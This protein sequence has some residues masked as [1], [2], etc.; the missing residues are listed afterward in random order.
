MKCNVPIYH[1]EISKIVKSLV[2]QF[3]IKSTRLPLNC[4]IYLYT[5]A[6][7]EVPFFKI[8]Y[9]ETSGSFSKTF[10]R[11]LQLLFLTRYLLKGRVR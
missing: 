5:E 10:I 6:R 11:K 9:K 7:N 4:F 8:I 2:I 1:R 3:Y